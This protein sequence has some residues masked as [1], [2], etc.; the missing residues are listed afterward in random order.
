MFFAVEYFFLKFSTHFRDANCKAIF[1]ICL[2]LLILVNSHTMFV[3][4]PNQEI[5]TIK[6]FNT[7]F[8]VFKNITEYKE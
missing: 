2:L 5:S 6:C 8:L 1:K 7:K 4:Q 3:M